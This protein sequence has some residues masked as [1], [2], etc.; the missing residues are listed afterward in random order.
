MKTHYLTPLIFCCALFPA[1]AT[2]IDSAYTAY[3][4]GHYEQAYLKFDQLLAEQNPDAA[5]QMGLMTLKEKGCEHDPAKALA[6]FE[7]AAEWGHPEGMAMVTEIKPRLNQLQLERAKTYQQEIDE[8]EQ[9]PQPL[10]D[11]E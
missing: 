5:M 3:K 6:L 11:L 10:A 8:R 1:Q 7:K 9:Q 4:K 2:D